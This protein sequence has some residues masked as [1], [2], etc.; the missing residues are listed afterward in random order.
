MK[1]MVMTAE[2]VSQCLLG[3]LFAAL[4][5]GWML[6][7]IGDSAQVETVTVTEGSEP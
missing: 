2:K 7:R 4:I 6:S 3:W 5:L 1:C